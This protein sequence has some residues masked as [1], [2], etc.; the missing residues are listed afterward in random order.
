MASMKITAQFK[1]GTVVTRE[2]DTAYAYA[3][4]RQGERRVRFHKSEQAAKT[5]AGLYGE[6]TPTTVPQAASGPVCPVCEGQ[7]TVTYGP[8]AVDGT[9]STVTCHRCGGTGVRPS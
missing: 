1:D 3:S 6:I 8:S 5:S 4:R 2:S 9:F 7:R